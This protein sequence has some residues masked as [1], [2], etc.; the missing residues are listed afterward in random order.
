MIG[1]RVWNRVEEGGV[2]KSRLHMEGHL[3]VA[4]S[5][6]VVVYDLVSGGLAHEVP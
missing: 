6:S 5:G 4:T 1:V 3:L 2:Q